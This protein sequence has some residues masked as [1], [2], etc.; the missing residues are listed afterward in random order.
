[1]LVAHAYNPSY[2]GGK[3]QEACGLKPDWQIV[4]ETL[5][6]KYSTQKTGLPSKH[7]ALSSNPYTDLPPKKKKPL[8]TPLKTFTIW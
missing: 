4:C 7:E 3:D 8:K 1:V 5:S 6:Q 2:S